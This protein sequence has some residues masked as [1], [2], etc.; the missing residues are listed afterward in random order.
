[1]AM[2]MATVTDMAIT[3]IKKV[4]Y[5]NL[6]S[7]LKNRFFDFGAVTFY[8]II[9]QLVGLIIGFFIVRELSIT[10]YAFY[11]IANT[12]LGTMTVLSDGGIS[13]GMLAQGG[14]VWQ[15]KQAMGKI[16]HTGYQLRIILSVA[17]LAVC[18]P[19]LV[20]FL[21][22]QQASITTILVIICALIPLFFASLSD[23]LLQIAPKLNKDVLSI[24]VNGL[25]VQILRLICI[26]P[27]LYIFPYCWLI[28]LITGLI[29]LWGNKRLKIIN[30]R[31]I[32]SDKTGTLTC[33][34]ME[35]KYMLIGDEFYGDL[36]K[37]E[38]RQPE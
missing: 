23:N 22:H 34:I 20:Y 3:R 19:L 35:F 15:D 4:E 37:F 29:R 6:N 1:M 9:I 28:L 26:L 31:Y 13:S 30:R 7:F 24:Q 10:E 14:A 11:T 5:I 25:K 36:P 8:Q 21:L 32:F 16:F 38:Q 12:M 27:L 17:V 18:L 33:N 2:A